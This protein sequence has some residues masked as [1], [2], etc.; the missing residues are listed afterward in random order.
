MLFTVKIGS[1]EFASDIEAESVGE[2]LSQ[3][4]NQ[5][6][7]YTAPSAYTWTR[8]VAEDAVN[9]YMHPFTCYG[10]VSVDAVDRIKLSVPT[11]ATQAY[12]ENYA[13]RSDESTTPDHVVIKVIRLGKAGESDAQYILDRLASGLHFGRR[14]VEQ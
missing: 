14:I 6:H 8:E 5:E 12:W 3:A 4:L 11:A 7:F 13:V 10:N 2:A 9:G 1:E